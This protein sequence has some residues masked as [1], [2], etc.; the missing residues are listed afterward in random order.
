MSNNKLT[1]IEM[2]MA[3]WFRVCLAI[4]HFVRNAGIQM[5]QRCFQRV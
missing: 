1:L 3:T 4:A 2:P 5:I